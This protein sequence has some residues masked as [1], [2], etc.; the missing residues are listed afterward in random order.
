MAD[1][2]VSVAISDH[3]AGDT[4]QGFGIGPITINGDTPPIEL[5]RVRMTI[6]EFARNTAV[7]VYDSEPGGLPAVI[8]NGNTWT[9]E[10]GPTAPADFPLPAGR[11]WGDVETTDDDGN[12]LTI[13]RVTFTVRPDLT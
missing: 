10:F 6:R 11:Y 9:A 8:T 13:Y 5:A 2:A 7:L 4:W 12:V 1:Y 3:H